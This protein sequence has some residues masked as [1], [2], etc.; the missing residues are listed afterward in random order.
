MS[1]STG[2]W[3]NLFIKYKFA[4]P[5]EKKLAQSIQVLLSCK[6]QLL[7]KP[8]LPLARIH[9]SSSMHGGS[10]LPPPPGRIS[11]LGSVSRGPKEKALVNGVGGDI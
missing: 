11:D 3:S 9:L 8:E 1:P 4:P 2:A 10:H 6:E 7:S 5:W